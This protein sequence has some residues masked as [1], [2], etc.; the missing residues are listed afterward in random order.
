[1]AAADT[2]AADT[3]AADT[4]VEYRGYMMTTTVVQERERLELEFAESQGEERGAVVVLPPHAGGAASTKGQ[5][6]GEEEQKEEVKQ[7]HKSHSGARAAT[8]VG[9]AVTKGST[10]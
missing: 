10:Q 7:Q 1:M 8:E 6:K 2:M 5:G 9:E 3:E 4:M